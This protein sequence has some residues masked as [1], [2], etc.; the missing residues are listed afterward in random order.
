MLRS[1]HYHN[2]ISF[3]DL[4]NC[5]KV[6]KMA[7]MCENAKITF[8]HPKQKKPFF[9]HQ[10]YLTYVELVQK[11]HREFFFSWGITSVQKQMCFLGKSGLLS[12]KFSNFFFACA[13]LKFMPKDALSLG[14]MTMCWKNGREIASP[15]VSK[16]QRKT[17]K[18]LEMAAPKA[19]LRARPNYYPI[20]VHHGM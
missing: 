6:P 10:N 12:K 15:K 17:A 4:Y 13:T 5:L 19:L 9:L 14:V 11:P 3:S 2:I 1:T 16:N 8:I 18:N 7:K 20:L